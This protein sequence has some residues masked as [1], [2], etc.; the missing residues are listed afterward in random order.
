MSKFDSDMESMLDAFLFETGELL[1]K[2]EDI[3]IKTEQETAVNEEDIGEIFRTMHTIKG[4]AAMMGLQNMSD[5]AHSIE[6]L[7]SILRDGPT[8][9]FDKDKVYD[10][11]FKALD[12]LKNE[13]DNL[14]DESVP[15]GD[16]SQLIA[17][18]HRERDR[19]KGGS[20]KQESSDISYKLES[21]FD[22]NEPEGLVTVKV[23]YSDKCMMPSARAMA[24]MRQLKKAG[25]ITKTIP[26]DL[27]ADS[28]D[29][30]ISAR[31]LVIKILA[32]DKAKVLDIA[33]R[34][35]NVDKAE[36]L[37][38]PKAEV[39][40]DKKAA[41]AP[42]SKAP[43]KKEQ[44]IIS[45]DLDKLDRLLD[46]VAEIV[47]TES[48]VVGSEDL[49]KINTG[50]ERFNKSAR[51]L[52]KL[53]D[54]LQDV[55]MS[56][57]MVPVSTV[58]HKMNRVVRD[59]NKKLGK[60]VTLKFEGEDTEVDKSI[61]DILGDPL[62]HIVRN[63][64]DH[65][66]E[67][68]EERVKAGK[69]QPPTVILKAEYDS[70]EAV[71]S[72]TDNGAGMDSKKILAKAKKNGLLTKPESEYTQKEVFDFVV[73]AGFSTNEEVTEYSGRGVGMD[74]V[75]NNI[76]KVGGKLTVDSVF[77]QGSTF[78][79]HIPLTLSIIDVLILKVGESSLSV[80]SLSVM[81]A[82]SCTDEEYILD[83]E[84]NEFICT[85]GKCYPLI[86][87]DDFLD[88]E[89]GERDFHKSIMLRCK[90]EGFEGVIMADEIIGDQQVV[91]KPFS[92]LLS[93][94]DLKDSGMSGTSIL[95]DGSITVILDVKEI[96]NKGGGIRDE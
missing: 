95:G 8:V 14:S 57:R 75:K 85:N 3:L 73:G 27:D 86:R 30:E 19:L 59:M 21:L 39:R 41:K 66:I 68:P 76:E 90:E 81:N 4:S 22:D 5:L 40:E 10:L 47:I 29:E 88:I 17:A 38:K 25:E 61:I 15:L 64:V 18:L 91:V 89:K 96:L 24:L 9:S 36:I 83:P 34:G 78:T 45:V 84:G 67:M 50:L 49:K 11:L 37:E 33:S 79:L 74:V 54:E 94:F 56:I 51:E 48:T 58:F 26:E 65:G 6:D 72:C 32:E 82:F 71:I 87:L 43:A 42:E 20:G 62:M 77:G 70:G 92:P 44:S 69:T 7:F 60:N 46:L 12:S 63:A 55:V 13:M 80:P 35:I 93:Q 52:R 16:F 53:T 28:A 1:E 23:T 31:G 2:F